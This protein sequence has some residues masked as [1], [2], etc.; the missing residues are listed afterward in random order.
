MLLKKLELLGF[1]SFAEKAVL[2]FPEGVLAVVGP[3]GSGK[4][5]VIDAIR[6]LLGEREAKNMRG[7]K[8][9]DLIFSG[10]PTRPRAGFAQASMTLDNSS[11]FFPVEYEEVTVSRRIDRDGTSKYLLNNSEVRAREILDFFAKSKLGARGL[12][13][14]NQGQ[15]D[16]FIKASEEERREMLEEILGLRTYQ[17]KKH[18]SELK[19]ESTRINMDKAKALVEEILPHLKV[20][21]KQAAK[22]EKHDEYKNELVNLEKNYYGSKLSVYKTQEEKIGLDIKNIDVAIHQRKGE[23]ELLEGEVKNLEDSNKESKKEEE[24]KRKAVS[25]RK[26]QIYEKKSH[27]ERELGKIEAQIEFLPKKKDKKAVDSEEVVSFFKD[28]RKKIEETYKLSDFEVLKSS[29]RDLISKIDNFF[30][31]SGKASEND[32]QYNAEKDEFEKKKK[33]LFEN[34]K[35]L[36]AEIINLSR[37]EAEIFNSSKEFNDAFRKS[38]IKVQDKNREISEVLSS[39]SRFVFELEK[40]LISK[41]EI[42]KEMKQ[43]GVSEEGL[44]SSFSEGEEKESERKIFR[45]RSE[46]SAIGEV[47]EAL[48]KEAKETETRYAFLSSQI[49]DLET[50]FSDLNSLIKELDEKIHKEF[51]EAM[52]KINHEFTNYFKLMFQGGSAK[53]TLIKKEIKEAVAQEGE[54]MPQEKEDEE[55]KKF[56]HGGIE[57]AVS[58]PKKKVASLESL[59]GGEKS[60]VSLA[61]LFAL[62]S[63][64]PPPFLVLDEIDAALDEANTKRLS[65]LIKDF[66]KK[67]QFLIVTHNRATMEIASVLYGVTLGEDG[68]SKLLSLKLE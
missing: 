59:S 29:L 1:K 22:W 6:W 2:E 47:D 37:E 60:L 62:I 3:N 54:E 64:S 8:A 68:S 44:I 16:I 52:V 51:K 17:I 53:L 26:N 39:R 19:L 34:L 15:S 20:L 43:F 38:F 23:L 49:Q 50:A 24:H 33:E 65:S 11:K 63:V 57:I 25:D 41:D 66:S 61:V 56:D 28:V 42:L 32:N 35:Q 13:I 27:I 18:E 7:A 9:E 46:I 31:D 48:L 5:N 55:E 30:D 58:L 36:E 40:I 10:T 21:R 4:S 12:T 45:L 14:I 67:T